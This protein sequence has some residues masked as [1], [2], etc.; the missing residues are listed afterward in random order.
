MKS[1]I[2]IIAL[3]LITFSSCK[4]DDPVPV[5][6]PVNHFVNTS[7]VGTNANGM[8]HMSFNFINE[9][10]CKQIIDISFLSPNSTFFDYTYNGYVAELTN[11]DTG[12]KSWICTISGSTMS[13]DGRPEIFKR[14]N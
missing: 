14:T 6:V 9:K 7:W 4:K 5:P 2:L 13:V 8:F 10:E 1:K 12:V 3:I 11:K